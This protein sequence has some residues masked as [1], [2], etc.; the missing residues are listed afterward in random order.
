[1]DAVDPLAIHWRKSSFSGTNADCV[2]VAHAPKL[3]AVRDSKNP[4][5]PVLVFPVVAFTEAVRSV[6]G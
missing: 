3:A 2:E 5:G 1:M 6:I 4:A